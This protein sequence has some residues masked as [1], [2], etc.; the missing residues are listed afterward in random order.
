VLE[1]PVRRAGDRVW[2][3]LAL[4]ETETSWVVWRDKITR[5]YDDLLGALD[6]TVT[7]IAATVV[8]RVE[9]VSV[10][11]AR[12]KPPGNMSAFECLLR[13]IDHHRLGSVTDDNARQAVRWFDRAI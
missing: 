7:R 5:Q 10:V 13:G 4:S 2:I 12:R 6:E 8:G 9:D 3:L 1:G 11:A